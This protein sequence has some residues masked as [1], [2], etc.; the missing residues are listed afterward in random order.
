MIKVHHYY[1][2]VT[3]LIQDV[4][5]YSLSI[6]RFQILKVFLKITVCMYIQN[7]YFT[8][9][10]CIIPSID[11]GCSWGKNQML[12][13]NKKKSFKTNKYIRLQPGDM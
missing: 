10:Y 9:M 12:G 1:H 13:T 8:Y 4:N 6:H 11:N 7:K 2:V 3:L 5:K